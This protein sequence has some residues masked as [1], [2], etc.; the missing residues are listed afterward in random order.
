MF[1][2]QLYR[3]IKHRDLMSL[4]FEALNLVSLCFFKIEIF[5]LKRL[6]TVQYILLY[7]TA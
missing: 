2:I 5:I 1:H 4:V 6:H 3:S 7:I